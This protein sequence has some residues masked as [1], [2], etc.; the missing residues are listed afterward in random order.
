MGDHD[1]GD[2]LVVQFLEH[3]HDFDAGLAVEVAGRL[4]GEQQR[5][6]VHQRAGDGDALLLAAGKLVGMMVGALAE[7]DQFERVHGA[8][9][10][11]VRLDA[12]AVVKHRHFDI[13]QRRGARQQVETLENKADF[14]VADIRQRVAVERGNVNAIQQIMAA[15]SDGPARRS[16][17]SACFCRSR[18]NP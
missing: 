16:C 9:V 15:A 2:A 12:V 5:R 13:F 7:A 17:S 6:L 1:D 4:V 11:L 3:A 18:S 8:F 10:L 14:F